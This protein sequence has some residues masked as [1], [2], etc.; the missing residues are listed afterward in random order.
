MRYNILIGGRAGQGPNFLTHFLAETLVSKGY[1]VFYSRDYQSL[2]RGGHN[3]N[4]LTFSE[5]PIYSN[6][7]EIDVLI[8]LDENTE[9]LHKKELKKGGIILKGYSENMYYAGSMF[10]LLGFSLKDLEVRIKELKKR[11]DENLKNAKKGFEEEKRSLC[12][13]KASKGKRIFTSGSE[14]IAQGAIDSGL[15]I[16]YA[17]PMTPATPILGEL[18]KK[19]VEKKFA[20]VEL[21]NEI[22]I[23]NAA[24][25]SAITGAK[26]MVGTSGGGFDLMSEGL[27][28]AGMA[29]IPLVC[30]LA[31]R[32]G[33]ASGVPTYTSQGD[34]NM[35]RHCGHGEFPRL[36]LAPGDPIECQELVSQAFYFSQ[37]FKTPTIIISD[38]HLAES[39]YTQN[40][41]AKITQSKKQ[42]SLAKYNSY[43]HDKKGIST[44]EAKIIKEGVERR[45]KKQQAI[46]KEAKKFQGYK[47]YGKKNSKNLIISWG[48]TKGAILDA[49]PNLNCSFLQILYIEPF[50]RKI[51]GILKGKNII[52]VENNSTAQLA[53]LIAE[54][55]GIFIDDK[56]K[57]LRYDARPFLCDELKEELNKR[58]K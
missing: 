36:V 25:G 11:V 10:K 8:E 49:I 52:L 5:S 19:Q 13:L 7:A 15:D 29:E 26:S 2:I 45:L 39:Y 48:S 57:I 22:S 17:Y 1:Y 58:I 28:M 32:P 34:L 44:E 31:Q 12:K 40:N 30:Y 54:K 16:Y 56:N 47:L 18:A 14:T 4:V 27:T 42:T 46:N 50:P 6:D 23:I 3:F 55:T 38:K 9:K 53:G 20:V 21:E 24:I 51:K 33:P 35:A 37:K 41:K 43:E